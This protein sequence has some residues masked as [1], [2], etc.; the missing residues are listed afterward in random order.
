MQHKM[1]AYRKDSIMELTV[2][3]CGQCKQFTRATENLRDLC[4]AWDQPTVA[5]RNAC[6]FFMANKPH[7]KAC[8][9]KRAS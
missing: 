9:T 2:N 3:R 4:A 6:E 5:T 7:R 1:C 8:E